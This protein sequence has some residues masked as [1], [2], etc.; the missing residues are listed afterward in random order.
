MCRCHSQAAVPACNPAL[1]V[2]PGV[3]EWQVPVRREAG[4]VGAG[5][6]HEA[7]H[8]LGTAERAQFLE[9]GGVPGGQLGHAEGWCRVTTLGPVQPAVV[10]L[11]H[12][13]DVPS[14]VARRPFAAG[15]AAPAA[16]PERAG[17]GRER[18]DAFVVEAQD[19]VSGDAG[20]G[21]GG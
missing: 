6:D 2:P 16:G 8:R 4:A 1:T 17:G 14:Q 18:V 9:R 11:R 19:G 20:H 3:A 5:G 7:R 12:G 10:P 21:A 15:G 13:Q